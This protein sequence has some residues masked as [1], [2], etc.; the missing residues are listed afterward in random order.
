MTIGLKEDRYIIICLSNRFKSIHDRNI[1]S[2]LVEVHPNAFI[3]RQAA[4]DKLQELYKDYGSGAEQDFMDGKMTTVAQYPSM[5]YL[6]ITRTFPYSVEYAKEESTYTIRVVSMPIFC[7]ELD[8][9][10]NKLAEDKTV[11]FKAD[12][13]T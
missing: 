5:D 12:D 6:T 10:Y 1:L 13:L 2:S 4:V 3:T 11:E 9:S 7:S 8:L